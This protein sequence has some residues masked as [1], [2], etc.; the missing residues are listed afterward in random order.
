MQLKPK[1]RKIKNTEALA[2]IKACGKKPCYML[3]RIWKLKRP[4]GA[5]IL[6]KRLS[7]E[8]EVRTMADNSGWV[9]TK[10]K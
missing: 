7:A 2:I 3:K 8:Y 1:G 9:I 10:L 5:Y 4:P 6:R